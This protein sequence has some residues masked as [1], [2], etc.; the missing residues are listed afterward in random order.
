MIRVSDQGKIRKLSDPNQYC[1]VSYFWG[2]G[3]QMQDLTII[4]VLRSTIKPVDKAISCRTEED[5]KKKRRNYAI[6]N[7]HDRRSRKEK[8]EWNKQAASGYTP[9]GNIPEYLMR[10]PL[11]LPRTLRASPLFS[12]C[13]PEAVT[14]NNNSKQRHCN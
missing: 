1:K 12:L 13:F 11:L 3:R 6:E 4:T 8:V 7:R 9:M 5:Q 14:V 2:T 10:N